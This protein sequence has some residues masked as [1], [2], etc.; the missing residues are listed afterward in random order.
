MIGAGS[1]SSAKR[2]LPPESGLGELDPGKEKASF[3]HVRG[4]VTLTRNYETM[5]NL[6]LGGACPRRQITH[7]VTRAMLH[8]NAPVDVALGDCDLAVF[9]FNGTYAECL[10]VLSSVAI[11]KRRPW[12]AATFADHVSP[13]LRGLLLMRPC[14][15]QLH[16]CL[17]EP[18]LTEVGKPMLLVSADRSQAF[19]LDADGRFV[20][21]SVPSP[22]KLEK[23]IERAWTE[24][25]RR[26]LAVT[27][28]AGEF[29]FGSCIAVVP[30]RKA[31]SR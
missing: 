2:R 3:P 9:A 28:E 1:R 24:L 31:R 22:A 18:C 15:G 11:D 12:L 6:N 4:N 8:P 23:G 17:V 13:Q 10:E 16:V 19:E 5:R 30:V 27:D 26:M 29:R 21:R 14:F 25:T 7:A 20:E